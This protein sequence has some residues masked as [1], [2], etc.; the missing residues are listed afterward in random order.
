VGGLGDAEHVAAEPVADGRPDSG[1]E[2]PVPAEARVQDD[3]AAGAGGQEPALQVIGI[4]LIAVGRGRVAPG[5]RVAQGDNDR[6]RRG[7]VDQDPGD[8]VQGR[9]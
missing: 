7:R 2:Q 3:G 9:E 6:A 4:P 5:D 1:P 8:P